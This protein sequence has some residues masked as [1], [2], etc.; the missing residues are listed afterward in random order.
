MGS[1]LLLPGLL[2]LTY[3][4]VTSIPVGTG[5]AYPHQG[6]TL[7]WTIPPQVFLVMSIQD[8]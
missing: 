4:E 5:P 6:A 2:F 8:C 1:R 3:G 7:F